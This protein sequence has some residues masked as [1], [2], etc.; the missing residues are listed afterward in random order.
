MR[1]KHTEPPEAPLLT[2]KQFRESPEFRKFKGIMRN[3]LKV[4]KSDLDAK[5]RSAK[6]RS[7]RL[8]NPNAVGRKAKV[9]PDT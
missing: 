8:A 6:K 3:I 9:E 7:P 5:I 4:S 1:V 2:T